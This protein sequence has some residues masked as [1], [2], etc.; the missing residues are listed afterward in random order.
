MLDF[1]NF[2]AGKEISWLYRIGV[3]AGRQAICIVTP[4]VRRMDESDIVTPIL[5]WSLSGNNWILDSPL[6]KSCSNSWEIRLL[7]TGPLSKIPSLSP[8]QLVSCCTS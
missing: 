7:F 1:P 5:P 6:G 4:P 2:K 3:V 8:I